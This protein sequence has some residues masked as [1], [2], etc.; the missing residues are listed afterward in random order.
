MS[1]I[2]DLRHCIEQELG[3]GKRRIFLLIY[4]HEEEIWIDF[5]GL[6]Y[7]AFLCAMCDG[8]PLKQASVGAK[9]KQERTFCNIEWALTEWGGDKVLVEAIK[10]RKS[11]I[12][13]KIQEYK[14]MVPKYEHS[15]SDQTT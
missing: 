10:T 12:L 7:S 11:K 1:D 6:P 15:R 8:T 2:R 9:K 14:Q 5:K 3:K 4:P 13:E